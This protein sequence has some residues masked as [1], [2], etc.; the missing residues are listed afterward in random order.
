MVASSPKKIKPLKIVLWS[1]LGVIFLLICVIVGTLL[2]EKF[3]KKSPVPM[4]MG[5]AVM[6]VATGS[7][8][9]TINQGDVIIVKKTDDYKL[10]DIVTF[11][12][13][14]GEVITHR[15][16]NY[17][18]PD[19]KTKFITKGDANPTKD[20][21]YIT[22][23]QIAGEV[24]YTIPKVGLFFDWFLHDFGAI[25]AIAIVAVLVVG[26]Y[27]ISLTKSDSEEQT[28]SPKN[29]TEDSQSNQNDMQNDN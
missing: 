25:Y 18:K 19:D 5:Y 27:F 28:E 1:I 13:K 6:T 22:L 2:V 29:V 23:D 21:G 16:I 7:M 20:N 14:N 12:N 3:I 10:G 15:L 17:Y 11:V 4:F 9:G 24:V 8:T 26:F